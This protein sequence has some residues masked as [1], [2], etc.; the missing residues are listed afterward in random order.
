MSDSIDICLETMRTSDRARYLCTLWAPKVQ[1]PAL[2]ALHT[3]CLELSRIRG[4]V[5]EPMLGEIRLAWWREA[6]EGVYANK[7]REHPVLQALAQTGLKN[8]I[9]LTE[10]QSLIE[11]RESEIFDMPMMSVKDVEIFSS[12]TAGLQNKLGARI[13]GAQ[14]DKQLESAKDI[15]TAWGMLCIILA[16]S[17]QS[18]NHSLPQDELQQ[19]GIDP[20]TLF[21]RPVDGA[22]APIIRKICARA[23]KLLQD[24]AKDKPPRASRLIGAWARDYVYR[25]QKAD[26]DI[27]R[28]NPDE[29]DV[30]RQFMLFRCGITGIY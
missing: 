27:S 15:G 12:Q 19:A 3:F 20:Q 14:T 4:L 25:L 10:M 24:A 28:L 18:Q 23:E 11:A 1:R 21:N 13:I 22:I 30:R 7:P 17:F 26:Y 5:S 8:I 9:P 6:L 16:I 29:G 2:V